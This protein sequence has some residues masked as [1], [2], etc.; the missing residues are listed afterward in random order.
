ME[1]VSEPR[2]RLLEDMASGLLQANPLAGFSQALESFS[3]QT[4]DY[5]GA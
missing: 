1:P 2:L 4:H 3:G 5:S